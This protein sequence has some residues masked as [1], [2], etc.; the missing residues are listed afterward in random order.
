M[1][2]VLL[3]E[4]E[5]ELINIIGAELASNQRDL[6]R[7]LDVSLGMTNILIRRLI[8]KGYIRIRQLNKRKVEY[9]LTPKGF[10]EKMR[11]SVKY[12]V[13][14]LNSISLIKE[15][16]RK[17]IAPYYEKG[18]RDFY[19]FGKSDITL[20][21]EMVLKEMPLDG[22]NVIYIKELPKTKIEGIVFIC[23]ED[24]TGEETNINN[25][26]D[27]IRELAKSAYWG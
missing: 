11:K 17:I 6:S 27:L 3:N 24:V 2:T 10:A 25:C 13:K 18:E 1:T 22:C 5:F 23:K 14:T 8:A 21:I 7:H 4:R 20:L 12:T 19:V 9:I 26:V 16:I 15:H